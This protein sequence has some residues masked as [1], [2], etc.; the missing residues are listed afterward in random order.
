L[1]SKPGTKTPPAK[2]GGQKSKNARLAAAASAQIAV[3]QEARKS[4]LTERQKQA[5]A[6]A[7]RR[8]RATRVRNIGIAAGLVIALAVGLTWILMGQAEI[9]KLRDS[10]GEFVPKQNSYHI[11]TV[12]SP[13][14]AY[15]TD[16]PT[17]GPHVPQ[18]PRW[19]VYDH[20]I[21]KELQVHALEDAGVVINYQPNL[22]KT[23]VDRL[24][25][26]TTSYSDHAEDTQDHY[27]NH[28]L[29][30]PYTGLDHPIVL[31]AWTRILRLDS[32]DEVK[33]KNFINA[34]K[35]IDHH[36]ESGDKP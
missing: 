34:Y 28:V 17:S 9:Q 24:A 1:S 10:A 33:I 11:N 2:G 36:K 31:T 21:R 8:Q 35:N 26:L 14:D 3:S 12:D 13:H 22:D 27:D 4:A 19:G 7:G 15:T 29:M 23:T 32:F 18:V 6:V 25:A 5:A 20:E 16:P 30:S